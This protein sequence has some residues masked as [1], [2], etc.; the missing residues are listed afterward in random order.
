MDLCSK[1]SKEQ[2]IAE[3]S[4][5]PEHGNEQVEQQDVGQYHVYGK[6][7]NDEP[8]LLWTALQ[9]WVL[10][11]LCLIVRTLTDITWRHKTQ[12]LNFLLCSLSY[13][14]SN[15]VWGVS[16]SLCPVALMTLI[17]VQ[18]LQVLLEVSNFQ[19]HCLLKWCWKLTPS[20]AY[21]S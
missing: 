6:E 5:Q 12:T 3:R 10:L 4:N 20:C 17:T 8:G 15:L 2:V 19:Q 7:Q 21:S 18:S 16:L 14:M 1:R 9:V 13:I 11:Q